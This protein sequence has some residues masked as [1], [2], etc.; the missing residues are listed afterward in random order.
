MLKNNWP[1]D[2]KGQLFY[3]NSL[4]KFFIDYII[5]N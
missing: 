2:K 4:D 1:F 5:L 3:V